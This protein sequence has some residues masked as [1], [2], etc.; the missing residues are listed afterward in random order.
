MKKTIRVTAKKAPEAIKQGLEILG[1]TIDEVEVTIISAGGLFKKAEV[2]L[3]IGTDDETPAA[4]GEEKAEVSQFKLVE[5]REKPKEDKK[6]REEKPYK[7]EETAVNPSA[8]PDA[9]K[10]QNRTERRRRPPRPSVDPGPETVKK[11]EAFLS[12]ALELA[13]IT[14]AL[15]SSVA[16]GLLINIETEDSGVIGHHGETLDAFQYLT[17]LVINEGSED[18]VAVTL[19]AFGYRARRAE[20][21]K[22][23]AFKMAEKCLKNNRR[24][25]LEPMNNS[26]RK[27][28]HAYLSEIEGVVTRSEGNE[29]NRKIIIYPASK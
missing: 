27:E 29:P 10:F 9:E 6:K 8:A 25:A 14:A 3:S 15:K 16:G 28:V 26:D 23:M 12:K 18:Y 7:K 2:E 24:V 20:I 4:A 19:D 17:S 13:G 11:A 5:N 21:L 22:R 1:A